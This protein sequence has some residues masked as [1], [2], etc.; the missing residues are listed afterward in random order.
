MSV[1]FCPKVGICL[2]IHVYINSYEVYFID[3]LKPLLNKKT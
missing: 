1:F 3:K 2:N